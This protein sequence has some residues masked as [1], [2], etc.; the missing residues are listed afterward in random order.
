MVYAL[1]ER[2]GENEMYCAKNNLVK[3]VLGIDQ[4]KTVQQ[5]KMDG[6]RR[7][8]R[9]STPNY[10]GLFLIKRMQDQLRRVVIQRR[11]DNDDGEVMI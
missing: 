4:V 9:A 11:D 10:L 1:S 6:A 7:V 5:D 8:F 3:A 2:T